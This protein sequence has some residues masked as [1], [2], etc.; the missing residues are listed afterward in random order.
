MLCMKWV[1]VGTFDDHEWVS[2]STIAQHVEEVMGMEMFFCQKTS[3]PCVVQWCMLWF[4]S[5][6]KVES[7]VGETRFFQIK[8][9][10]EAVNMAT[11]YAIS[12]PFGGEHTPRSCMLTSV[13][14]VPH[15]TH[16]T[17]RKW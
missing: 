4:F 12:R 13:A 16:K 14:K 3:S 17:H 5:T 2:E 7:N 8:K 1:C 9:C 6:Y 10:H 15:K 11:T